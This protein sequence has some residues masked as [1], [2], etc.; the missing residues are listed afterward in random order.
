MILRRIGEAVRRQDWFV[1]LV[2]VLV[3]V[4][5]VFIGL[6]VDDWNQARKDRALEQEYLERLYADLNYTLDSRE[7]AAEWDETR[8][9]QQ[10][11]V[12]N[13]LR[14]GHLA[15][16]DR[17]AFETGLA[18][19]GFISGLEIR[20]TTVDEL[21][22]TGTMNLVRDV[23]LRSQ[24]LNLD[25]TIARRQGISLRFMDSVYAFR[26]Q[27]GD[28]FGIADFNG[29]RYD[30]KL[31]YDFETLAADPGFV[32]ALS[33]IDFFSRFRRDLS[34]STLNEIRDFRDELAQRLGHEGGDTP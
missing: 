21:Q 4:F 18:L 31:I 26:N 30:V 15:E 10:A 12:L 1:V 29:E 27:I 16:E 14:T 7:Q 17:E 8:M 13:A 24:I 22:S 11:L 33:Q 5:G 19:F 20:W 2:E 23:T 28:Q 9:R 6:Q 3:V 25:A 34:I 32:N